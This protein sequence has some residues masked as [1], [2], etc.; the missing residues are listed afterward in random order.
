MFDTLSMLREFSVS[1]QRYQ[2]VLAGIADGRTVSE[3][4]AQWGVSRQSVHAWLARYEAEGLTGLTDRSHRPLSSPLQMRAEVEALVLELRRQ[5]RGWG[6]RRLV[7]EVGKRGVV[8]VP[9]ESGVYRALRRAGLIEPG[10][11]RKRKET[12]K[13][14]ERGSAILNYRRSGCHFRGGPITRVG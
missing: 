8:P 4:A 13:R 10:A 12:W 9:S 6:P 5:H 2:A 11:R 3:V 7:F 14:W 1:E